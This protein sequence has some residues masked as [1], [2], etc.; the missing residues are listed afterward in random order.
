M[1]RTNQITTSQPL[2]LNDGA[3]VVQTSVHL[4]PATYALPVPIPG[5]T[6]A[7]TTILIS[8][9]PDKATRTHLSTLP[10]N[11]VGADAEAFFCA[12]P[13]ANLPRRFSQQPGAFATAAIALPPFSPERSQVVQETLIALRSSHHFFT[14]IAALSP[15]PEAWKS[16]KGVDGWVTCS[17]GTEA[18]AASQLFTALT[19]LTSPETLADIDDSDVG[20]AL[21]STRKPAQLLEG[22]W[23]CIT[24]KMEWLGEDP[25]QSIGRASAAIAFTL[26]HRPELH[27]AAIIYRTLRAI[28]PAHATVFCSSS[29][30]FLSPGHISNAYPVVV[31]W[32]P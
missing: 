11:Y 5:E 15:A 25:K 3:D 29:L 26:T 1:T 18:F 8:F 20:N 30:N 12:Q 27:D 2:P 14:L 23:N 10:Y 6:M 28:A 32:R 19:T 16:L 17:L 4:I 31:L 22:L 7:H 24:Q 13:A 9:L 21:G